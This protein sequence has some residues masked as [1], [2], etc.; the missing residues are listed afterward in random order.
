[1]SLSESAVEDGQEDWESVKTREKQLG[2]NGGTTW[3]RGQG[4]GSRC[5]VFC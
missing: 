4:R 1:M 2:S 3:P 5:H